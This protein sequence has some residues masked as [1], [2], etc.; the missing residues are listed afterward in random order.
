MNTSLTIEKPTLYIET[1]DLIHGLFTPTLSNPNRL[2]SDKL[3]DIVKKISFVKDM[4]HQYELEY[5]MN[6]VMG[7]DTTRSKTEDEIV[8]F[9]TK[10]GI[11]LPGAYREFI[12]KTGFELHPYYEPKSEPYHLD[13]PFGASEEHGLSTPDWYDGLDKQVLRI[14][15]YGCGIYFVLLLNGP[16]MGHVWIEDGAN[17]GIA[18]PV[19]PDNVGIDRTG[20]LD[21]YDYWLDILITAINDEV[22]DMT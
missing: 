16:E 2:V 12:L 6:G 1:E 11:K 4:S 21:W 5:L 17:T 18:G 10:H 3:T 13:L 22:E 8:A 15:D 20:F 14:S 9:E 7:V 19:I